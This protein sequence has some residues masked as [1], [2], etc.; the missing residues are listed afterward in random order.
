M[1]DAAGGAR[2]ESVLLLH[3][4]GKR[5]NFGTLLR[6]AQA[7][8]VSEIAVAGSE[9]LRTFGNQGTASHCEIKPFGKLEDAV[10]HYRA[11]GFRVCGVEITDTAVPVETHPFE[12]ST[13][14]MVGNEGTGMTEK[15]L[16]ACDGFV[17]IP[18]FSGATASLNVATAGAIVLHHFATWAGFTPQPREGQKFVTEEPRGKLEVFENP[19][20][21]E[22]ALVAEKRA[23]RARKRQAAEADIPAEEDAEGA[24]EDAA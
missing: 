22:A 12:G 9:K 17:Y 13:V 6:S 4:V 3:N 7:F 8:G 18:Q 14:F 15:Q 24:A 19:T 10:Q 2:H 21:A 11:R 1:A 16:A 20:E 23:A 5:Q